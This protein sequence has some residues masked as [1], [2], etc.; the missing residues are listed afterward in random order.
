MR[1]ALSADAADIRTLTEDFFRSIGVEAGD[2]PRQTLASI[3]LHIRRDVVFAQIDHNPLRYCQLKLTEK[4][5][6]YL[7]ESLLPRGMDRALLKPMLQATFDAAK[8]ARP[9][10][11]DWPLGAS[12]FRAVDENGELD[13]GLSECK[14]WVAEYPVCHIWE[15]GGQFFA[16]AT[17]G[18]LAS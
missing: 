17:L 18:E 8:A 12:F 3:R 1:K 4:R 9:D 15:E 5:R 14:A 2:T 11:L 16:G 10:T 7:V 6:A 13:G